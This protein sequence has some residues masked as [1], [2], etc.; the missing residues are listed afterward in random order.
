MALRQLEHQH[1]LLHHQPAD[2]ER[3]ARLCAEPPRQPE[4]EA[5]AHRF[6]DRFLARQRTHARR[7]DDLVAI[8]RN[9]RRH[10]R[11]ALAVDRDPA[12]VQRPVDRLRQ[13]QVGLD[14]HRGEREHDRRQPQPLAAMRARG[15]GIERPGRHPGRERRRGATLAGEHRHPRQQRIGRAAMR[16]QAIIEQAF[17]Q[18]PRGEHHLGRI[19]PRQQRR[20]QHGGIGKLFGAHR[21]NPLA[22]L[23]GLALAAGER[24]SDLERCGRIDLEPVRI[25]QRVAARRHREHRHRAPRAAYQI[26]RAI[27]LGRG[28]GQIPSGL[29]NHLVERLAHVCAPGGA[30]AVFGQ[31][32]CAERKCAR[33]V[34]RA[35]GNPHQ[36]KASAAQIG[37]NPVRIGEGADHAV[38][39]E[40]RF[41]LARD[42]PRLQSDR[43]QAFHE[44]GAVG[45]I[46]HRGCGDR[47][48][49]LDAQIP[50]QQRE[51][52]QAA[53]RHRHRLVR[54][55]PG[56]GDLAPEL[57]GDLLVQQHHRRAHRATIDDQPHRVRTNIDDRTAGRTAGKRPAAVIPPLAIVHAVPPRRK[58]S[59]GTAP[60]SSAPPRPD[61]DGFV[62]K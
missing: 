45:G 8:G 57:G 10:H 6:L 49:I 22:T 32:Q 12:L 36:F 48:D 56:G 17:A 46:A 23:Q 59:L 5:P 30:F 40:E 7:R 62:M 34:S 42:D 38:G 54:E 3:A 13:A 24:S 60:A 1:A 14:L 33:A 2:L 58:L 27:G 4:R 52:L 35:I 9:R 51:P 21:R 39:A 50:E 43:A 29:A 55:P 11:P 31:A 25:A 16:G 18:A 53:Q 37:D 47:L 41:F 20:Q 19:E 44:F 26:E 28:G 15:C 61:S